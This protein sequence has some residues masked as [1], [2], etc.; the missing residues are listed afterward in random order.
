[1]YVYGMMKECDIEYNLM[2]ASI[3]LWFADGLMN[4]LP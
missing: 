4:L 1:M 2:Q 3:R